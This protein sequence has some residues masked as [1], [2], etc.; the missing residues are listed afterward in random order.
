MLSVASKLNMLSVIMFNVVMLNVVAPFIFMT[1]RNIILLPIGWSKTIYS[2]S[3]LQKSFFIEN[4]FVSVARLERSKG[5][6]AVRPVY[7]NG[8]A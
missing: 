7:R 8:P 5:P 2:L 6:G 4:I 3:S 1:C